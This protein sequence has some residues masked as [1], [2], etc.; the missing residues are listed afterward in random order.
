MKDTSSAHLSLQN[1]VDCYLE[2]NPEDALKRWADNDW[3]VEKHEDTDE[4]CLKYLALVLLDAIESRAHKIVLERGCPVLIAGQG[5]EHMLPAAPESLAARGLE[6]LRD[7]C[8]M[9]GTRAQG[10][11]CLGIRNNSL[12]LRIEKSEALH[13]IY[14]PAL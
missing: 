4:F 3:K 2:T 5:S 7:I 8:G 13:I 1:L 12:E 11:L 9:E 10:T 14:L 6:I